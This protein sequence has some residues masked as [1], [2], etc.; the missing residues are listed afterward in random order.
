VP[1]EL[2]IDPHVKVLDQAVVERAKSRGLDAVVYAPH[3]GRRPTVRERAARFSD[4]EL[5]VVPGREVVAGSWRGRK[6]VLGVGLD[7]P[8]PDFIGFG[9]AMDE[10]AR[11]DAA[12]LVPHPEFAT[13]SLDATDLER[14]RER[15]D[16]VEVYNPKHLSSHN[17]NARRLAER[18]G[19]PAFGSSYAHLPGTVGEVWTTFEERFA[20]EDELLAAFASGAPRRL[21]RRSGLSHRL[22]CLAEFAHLGYENSWE[23]IDRVLLS[24]MEATHPGHVAYG[25]RFDDV[26]VY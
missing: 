25:G 3:F 24:G 8:V 26:R 7:D 2:R 22:R 1:R 9:A 10:L 14:H 12:V 17:R 4:D 23:K 19:L 6:H 21:Q 18:Y 11:Q 5:L 16:A 15:I 13:V 20:D